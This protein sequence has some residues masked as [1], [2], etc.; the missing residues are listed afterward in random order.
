MQCDRFNELLTC[1]SS[2]HVHSESGDL[3][4]V[5]L[6]CFFI[7]VPAQVSMHVFYVIMF[8]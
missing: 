6:Q 1:G 5:T 7:N 2:A 3:Y 8:A 4:S